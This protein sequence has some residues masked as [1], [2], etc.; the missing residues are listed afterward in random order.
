MRHASVPKC[1]PLARS[2]KLVTKTYDFFV[3]K[4]DNSFIVLAVSGFDD[5]FTFLDVGKRETV[6]KTKNC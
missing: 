5:S 1:N 3:F 6:V 2:V 4:I